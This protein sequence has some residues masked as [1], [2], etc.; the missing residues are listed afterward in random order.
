M[1]KSSGDPRALRA[2]SEAERAAAELKQGVSKARAYAAEVK[3]R[4]GARSFAAEGQDSLEEDFSSTSR[5][6]A[7]AAQK[8]E[9]DS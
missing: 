9:R 3:S 2:Q 1:G 7:Y 6:R 4:L 8:T 5:A